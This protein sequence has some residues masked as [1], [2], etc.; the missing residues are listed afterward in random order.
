MPSKNPTPTTN[1]DALIELTVQMRQLAA[2]VQKLEDN[3]DG[4]SRTK[5]MREKITIAEY[6]IELN[7]QSF[8]DM[9]ESISKVEERL[10]KSI[11][12]AMSGLEK[13]ISEKFET[14][15]QEANIQKTTLEK[16]TPY[17]NA[18]AWFLTTAS[19]IVLGLIF[20]GKLHFTIV[21]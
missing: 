7:K 8:K 2:I 20:S 19:F 16:I 13:S 1:S 14:L 18:M 21:P 3:I 6:N 5:G 12:Q 9:Q 4:T 11:A 10:G 17:I 15:K